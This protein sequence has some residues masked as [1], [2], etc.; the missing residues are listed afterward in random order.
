MFAILGWLLPASLSTDSFKRALARLSAPA[1]LPPHC[2]W[3]DSTV[4]LQHEVL[5]VAEVTLL[6]IAR[7]QVVIEVCSRLC[8]YV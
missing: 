4:Q 2:S 1:Q 5:A 7:V 6:P 8:S 3:I